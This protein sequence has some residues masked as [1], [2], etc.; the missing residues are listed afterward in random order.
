MQLLEVLRTATS[1]LESECRIVSQDPIA[2]LNNVLGDDAM[3]NGMEDLGTGIR[4]P[5]VIS[6]QGRKESKRRRGWAESRTPKRTRNQ[7]NTNE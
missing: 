7:Q 2:D 1:D 4:D 5:P 3:G 6:R